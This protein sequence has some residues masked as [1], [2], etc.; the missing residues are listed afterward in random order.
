MCL[1]AWFRWRCWLNVYVVSQPQVSRQDLSE[2][3]SQS[4]IPPPHM[5]LP[6]LRSLIRI[7]PAWF[8]ISMTTLCLIC[9]LFVLFSPYIFS[10]R[11]LSPCTTWLVCCEAGQAGHE[12]SM[13]YLFMFLE[14]VLFEQGLYEGVHSVDILLP[15][16]F[17]LCS[18][19]NF[20]IWCHHAEIWL[21]TNFPRFPKITG[22]GWD[23]VYI[24]H[25]HHQW[26]WHC[27]RGLNIM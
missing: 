1:W 24:Q 17:I 15:L 27:L 5:A 26:H 16:L 18:L 8:S 14:V 9:L 25:I 19:S 2:Q 23:V 21:I 13:L 6:C 3:V 12:D 7:K 20:I 10:L 11:R 4:L 22:T